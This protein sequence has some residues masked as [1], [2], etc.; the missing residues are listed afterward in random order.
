MGIPYVFQYFYNKYN[1]QK[2]LMIDLNQ[3]AKM[4]IN[5]LFFDYNSLI[6]PCAQQILSANHDKYIMIEDIT[7]RNNQIEDD[8]IKNCINYTKLLINQISNNNEIKV[9]ITI[10]GVAPRSKMNQQ[11]ERRY[12]SEFFKIGDSKKSSLWDSNKITPGT[13]F[14]DKI[15]HSLYENKDYLNCI[16]SDSNEVGEGEHKIMKIITNLSNKECI[17]I[18]GL[19]ADLIML[20]LMNKNYDKIILI[21]DN[22][23]NERYVGTASDAVNYLNISNLRNYICEDILSLLKKYKNADIEKIDRENIIYDYIFMCFFLGNDFLEHLP[24]LYIKK[25]GIDIIINGYISVWKG[26]HLINKKYLV[27]NKNWISCINLYYLKDLMYQ[28]KN[29]ETYFFKNFKID[30]LHV[31]EINNYEKLLETNKIVFYK[32]DL[33]KFPQ[34]NYKTRYYLYYGIKLSEIDKICLHYIEGLY[35][36]FGYY[37]NHIH[38]NWS[39]F[40]NYHNTPFCSDL[41]ETLKKISVENIITYM[42]NSNNLKCS[43]A[44]SP[45]KQLYMVLPKTSLK[46]ILSDMNHNIDNL[47]YTLFAY[48]KFYPEKIYVDLW[49]KKYLWQTKIFFENINE[50]VLDLFIKNFR[51]YN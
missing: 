19:D 11:R 37:N 3:L 12:K 9:Y 18:Y 32:D 45:L 40:Y 46:G 51:L 49:S 7:E 24:S 42:N 16:I 4:K 35:W 29:N 5:Y 43:A 44:Y 14:M 25:S 10:D 41:F 15:K 50:E 8:I 38:N 30:K 39:W 22:S 6:H 48:N 23:F 33:I 28:L 27:Q 13:L 2:E 20:S 47:E 31:S 26:F 1:C 21:R 36:I 34:E 17:C